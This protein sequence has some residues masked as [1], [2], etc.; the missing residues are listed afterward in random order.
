MKYIYL[1]TEGKVTYHGL[2][3]REDTVRIF[4]SLKVAVREY[5]AR[6][7][8][9]EVVDQ[10][11]GCS[12][13]SFITPHYLDD[14]LKGFDGTAYLASAQFISDRDD[15]VRKDEKRYLILNRHVV[16]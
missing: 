7:S 9:V 5:N 4:Q 1:L 2:I 3:L 11:G 13:I 10:A 16:E 6:L 15:K 14:A 12:S 8:K